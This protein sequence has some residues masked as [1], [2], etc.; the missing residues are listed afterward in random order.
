MT[1]TVAENNQYSRFVSDTCTLGN[2]LFNMLPVYNSHF[3]AFVTPDKINAIAMNINVSMKSWTF[4]L[5][6]VRLDLSPIYSP[7]QG[8]KYEL[9]HTSHIFF[10]LLSTIAISRTFLFFHY[11]HL[12]WLSLLLSNKFMPFLKCQEPN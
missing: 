9:V 3:S 5:F 6:I 2:K 1:V 4:F 11:I 12:Y 8:M 10:R 7:T